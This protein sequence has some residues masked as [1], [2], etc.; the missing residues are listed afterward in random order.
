MRN[1]LFQDSSC[2]EQTNHKQGAVSPPAFRGRTLAS[3]APLRET[4]QRKRPCGD[5][6][7]CATEAFKK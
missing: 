6:L 2:A 7:F 3:Y 4:V 1:A 5:C